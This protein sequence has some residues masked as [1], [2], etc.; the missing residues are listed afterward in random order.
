MSRIMNLVNVSGG[1][2][3]TALALLAIERETPNLR[4]V[5]GDTGNEAAVT[6]EYLDYLDEVIF[7]RSG[8]RIQRVKADFAARLERKKNT[9]RGKWRK[10]GVPEDRIER[11]LAALVPS[12]NPFLDLSIWK[13]FFPRTRSRFCTQE[14]KIFPVIQQV[15]EPAIEEGWAAVV[16]WL[17][18]RRAESKA[19][20]GLEERGVEFGTWEP[21][22]VGNLLYR[23]ILDWSAADVFAFHRRHGVKWNPLYEQGAG[24]VGCF[25]CIHSRKAEIRLI[26][27][28]YPEEIERLAGWE[29][30]VGRASK[31]EKSLSTFFHASKTPGKGDLRSH[32][33]AVAEW[34]LTDRGGRQLDLT[35]LASSSSCSSIYGLCEP[36]PTE[37]TP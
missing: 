16:Q 19:R 35:N 4:F 15:I 33:R 5:F 17:G 13:G 12:A 21:E 29:R 10:D 18:V 32:I 3:S 8:Q 25:P 11:A 7:K 22:P 20:A 9:V 28:R 2:D 6:Y 34:A 26:A 37:E 23:P 31:Q 14:L 1:K 24:R 30:Q 27:Q 36:H